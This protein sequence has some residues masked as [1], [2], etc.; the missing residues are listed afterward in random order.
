MEAAPGLQA[1]KAV[2]ARFCLPGDSQN[3]TGT[4]SV[5]LCDAAWLGMVVRC[6]IEL[7]RVAQ[8]CGRYFRLGK[9]ELP[10]DP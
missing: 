3:L 10:P 2:Q 5:A 8:R 1:A 4:Q 6:W 9:L 7:L